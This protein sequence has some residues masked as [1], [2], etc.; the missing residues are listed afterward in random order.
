MAPA[1]KTL[2]W[3]YNEAIIQMG[4]I[5]FFAV[6]FPLAPM[7]SFMTNLIEIRI[8]LSSMALYGKRAIPQG[9]SGIGNWSGIMSL[10]S[11]VAIPINLC[12][13]IY[14]RSPTDEVGWNQETSEIPLEEESTVS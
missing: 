8:K 14:A 12:I 9:S 2:V 3:Y 4:Y 10:I 11:F 1:P 6:A 5:A 13:L 7:F